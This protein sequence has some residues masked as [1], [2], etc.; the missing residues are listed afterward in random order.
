MSQLPNIKTT[1][2]FLFWLL[3]FILLVESVWAINYL[4]ENSNLDGSADTVFT[5]PTSQTPNQKTNT[6]SSQRQASLTLK[7]A[8]NQVVANE[9]FVVDINLNT[10][11][12]EVDGVTL[13]I[14]FDQT[15]LQVVDPQPLRGLDIFPLVLTNE[16]ENGRII[17][18]A[19]ANP[20]GPFFKG[21]GQVASVTFKAKRAGSAQIKVDFNPGSTTETNIASH[22]VPGTD[23]LN[24]VQ[25]LKI[26]IKP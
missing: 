11:N 15:L 20:T 26:E 25:D 23:I 8:S 19:V 16:Q 4:S 18:R 6:E 14:N 2:G 7:T 13:Y 24:N 1:K 22:N 21:E 12:E 17:Y 9:T 5:S 3:L 10:K